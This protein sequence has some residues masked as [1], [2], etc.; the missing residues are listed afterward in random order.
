MK[1]KR[2]AE[3]RLEEIKNSLQTGDI[4]KKAKRKVLLEKIEH[5]VVQQ[6]GKLNI[7]YDKTK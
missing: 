4:I 2:S 1:E 6:N 7:I 5:I 3:E